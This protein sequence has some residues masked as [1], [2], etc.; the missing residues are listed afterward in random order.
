MLR[1]VLILLVVLAALAAVTV[2][3][4]LWRAGQFKRIEPH[5]AGRC[6]RVPGVIGAEDL[7][8]HPR[9]GVVYVSGYDRR[10]ALAGRPRPGG[11]YAY[12][13]ADP[14]GRLVNLTPDADASFQPHGL[15][16]W[17]GADG[18][19]VLFVINHPAP[20]TGRPAH[21]VE[22]FELEAG[23]LRHRESLADPELLVMPNDLVAVGPDR[24]YL[25][26]THRNPPG[27]AQTVETLLRRPGANVLYYDGARFRVAIPDLVYP[28]GINLSRDG[29]ALY[30]AT[31]TPRR[32]LV[33]E[34]DPETETLSLR[35]EVFAGSGLDNIEVDA[36]GHL[37][38][39]AHP[40]LLAV[41]AHRDDASQPAPSQ[42]LR[43]S[44][45]PDGSYDVDEIYLNAG[46]EIAAASVAARLGQR[47]V[48]G[49]I[50]G[51]GIL[52]C[53]MD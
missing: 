33:F 52:D 12:E 28:N 46:D 29:R 44:P 51:D 4:F 21:T 53:V 13:L 26:N 43:V 50:F 7:T 27:R 3:G 48:I 40:K 32:L 23:A 42:V 9:T 20:G 17:V 2:L 38:I 41:T 47:L 25:T 34:R 30:V 31:V 8:I 22:V 35:D 24:F 18:R 5:F 10:A 11:I 14:A 39:G 19:G 1:A 49:Q 45:R 37:W 6:Q 36:D 15:S 16:L